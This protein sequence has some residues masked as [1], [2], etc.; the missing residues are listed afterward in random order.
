[1]LNPH[2]KSFVPRKVNKST[3]PYTRKHCSINEVIEYAPPSTYCVVNNHSNYFNK[4]NLDKSSE[5]D[6]GD[7]YSIIDKLRVDNVNKIIIAHLNINSIRNKFDMLSDIVKNKIDILCITETKLDDTFPLS[8][9]LIQGFSP[10]YRLNRQGKQGGGLLTYVRGDI[11]SKELKIVPIPSDLECLFFE[12]NLYNKKW[13][14][15]NFYNPSKNLITS[16]INLLVS[17]LDHYCQLYDNIILLGDFNSEITEPT[18]K[19]FCELFDLKNLVKENTCFKSLENPSCIDLILT[20]RYRSFQ[21]THTIETGLSDFHKMT[22]TVLKTSY[23]KQTPKIVSYRDYKR[24]SND[25]FNNELNYIIGSYD[26]NVIDLEVFEGL[27]MNILNNHAPI[28]LKYIRANDG[29]FMNKTLRKE[30]MIRSKLKNI[31]NKKKTCASHLAYKKQRNYCTNLFRKAKRDFYSNLNPSLI[32]DN[33]KFWKTVKPF[34]SDKK[35]SNES[36]TLIENNNIISSDSDIAETFN[37]FFANAVKNLNINVDSALITNSDHIEDPIIRA[38]EKYKKHPSIVKIKELNGNSMS[39]KFNQSSVSEITKEISKLNNSKSC[40]IITIPAKIIKLNE[41]FFTNLIH[42][43]FNSSISCGEFPNNLKLADI[44]PAHKNGERQDKRNYRPVSILSPI[45]KI[46]ER[47]LYNQLYN[48]FDDILSMSQCGFRKGFSAQ[49]CLIVMLEKFK[50]S[51]DKNGSWGA[52]LTDLS[53]A[54]D[55]LLH[56]LL[57]AKLEAYGFDYISLKLMYSYLNSRYQ[58]VRIN[59]KYSSWSEITCGVP[60]G[61]ILGPL[62][63]NIYLT[64]LFLFVSPNICNY[65]DDNSPYNTSKDSESVIS[66]LE[67]EAKLLL[68]WLQNNAFKANPDKSHLL[69]NSI[70]DISA[71]IGGHEIKNSNV[72]KLLGISIDNELKF[73]EHVSKLCKKAGQK[74]HA[75]SRIS[76]YMNKDRRRIIMKAFI[77]SQFGYCPLIWMC[78][79]RTLNSRINRIHERALRIVYSDYISTFNTL[80]EKDKSFKVHERNIQTLAIEV[81]KVVNGLSP[82]IMNSIFPLKKALTHC[83]KQIFVTRNIKTVNYGLETISTLGP[84]IW[85]I[86]PNDMKLSTD[87]VDFKKKIRSWKPVKCP[88]RLCKVY[89]QGVGFVDIEVGN[90][91]I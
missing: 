53:K 2:A 22:V 65:A 32:S 78:H 67:N 41:F 73:N 60:Q 84:K 26:L 30:V 24:F 45:S 87:L 34:F 7:V 42:G 21:N 74:L 58:R 90:D 52:L 82:K 1:M 51:I 25:N 11:P 81:F 20:N 80:L 59:S 38:I 75:L 23:K 27:Y 91:N 62:L 68:Q 46:Y 66:H 39:F 70:D 33:K 8:N 72:V 13:I 36:I 77:Q 61:S 44:T 69:L 43:N 85:S 6:N 17:C 79:S 10:P 47:I 15:G 40:P 76:P 37:D 83:S 5:V 3:K 64:D 14:L 63:F 48:T 57:I 56:E 29:P 71:F 55:C 89:I 4:N 12:I 31:C 49:H 54:F 16:N 35:L 18:M 50:E 9:F 88:C 86:L 28:K 19:E